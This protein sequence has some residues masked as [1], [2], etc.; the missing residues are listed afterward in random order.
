MRLLIAMLTIVWLGSWVLVMALAR[1]ASL[2]D[3]QGNFAPPP[4]EPAKTGA[5]SVEGEVDSGL[6]GLP[7]DRASASRG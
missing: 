2:A 4:K 7:L 6:P 5:E 1:A 3:S